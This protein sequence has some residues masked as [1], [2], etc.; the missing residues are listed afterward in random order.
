MPIRPEMR[1]RYPSDWPE[2]SRR[3]REERAGGACEWCG[4]RN[5]EPHPETGSR[6]VL[7]VA[8]IYDERPENVDERNLAALCQRCHN[9]HD[10]PGRAQRMRE[11]RRGR[12]TALPL[13]EI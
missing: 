5:G 11:R 1:E 8:H 3:I 2:I 13:E 4:A 7:T 12:A 10:A 9:E 6:V